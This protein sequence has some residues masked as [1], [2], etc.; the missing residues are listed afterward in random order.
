[1]IER[2]R[3]GL[4]LMSIVAIASACA[5][6]PEPTTV[7]QEQ[8]AAEEQIGE[9]SQEV[10]FTSSCFNF[11]G[12]CPTG[13]YRA[14]QTCSFMCSGACQPYNAWECLPIPTPSG[15]ISASPATVNVLAGSLGTSRI[16]WNSNVSNSQVY[17]STNGSAEQLYAQ[18][19]SGCQDAPW[20]Q[21]GYNY[22]FNLY[23]G[24]AHSNRLAQVRVTGVLYEPP[25]Y[26]EPTCGP[27]NAGYS[28][29]CG[30]ICRPTN[31]YCP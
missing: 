16:C 28:C 13:Y 6:E 20:I 22:D 10:V 15:T 1:M 3:A 30:D 18:G 5:G 24:T 12:F 17:V 21:I 31:Q 19:T 26:E 8:I 11:G 27:C 25:P 2:V 9:E 4:L 29:H 14:Y 7:E 23:A